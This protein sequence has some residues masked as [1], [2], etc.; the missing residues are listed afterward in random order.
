MGWLAVVIAA[1]VWFPRRDTGGGVALEGDRSVIVGCDDDGC[2][3]DRKLGGRVDAVGERGG[4]LLA[5]HEHAAVADEGDDGEPPCGPRRRP[6]DVPGKQGSHVAAHGAILVKP[7]VSKAVTWRRT[8]PSW[9][10]QVYAWRPR[11][12]ARGAPMPVLS[13]LEPSHPESQR[14]DCT[15]CNFVCLSSGHAQNLRA[16]H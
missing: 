11:A 16:S 3:F 2:G 7:R 8:G 4:E 5:G 13:S 6:G 15:S 1:A 14:T 9:C 12:G 10:S